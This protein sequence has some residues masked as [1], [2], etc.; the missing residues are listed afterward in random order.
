MDLPPSYNQNDQNLSANDSKAQPPDYQPSP[1]SPSLLTPL[2][3]EDDTSSSWQ[4][5]PHEPHPTL[6]LD[7]CTIYSSTH[8]SRPLYILSNAPVEALSPAY[9]LEKVYYKSR[10]L[11]D[12]SEEVKRSRTTYIY[13]IALE[14][15]AS[16][17]KSVKIKGQRSSKFTY[18]EVI[19]SG[20]GISASHYKAS[21]K[22][23]SSNKKSGS[24]SSSKTLPATENFDM[25][26]TPV[27]A[28]PRS[29]LSWKSESS[30]GVLLATETRGTRDA[31]GKMI[32]QP[33]LEIAAGERSPDE[34]EMDILVAA[35]CARV[36][37][38]AAKDTKEPMSWSKFK[39]IAGTKVGRYDVARAG[40]FL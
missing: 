6:I 2:T 21:V 23:P 1:H 32:V 34:K 18:R 26:I 12:G 14:V 28:D 19:L 22:G 27:M 16:I 29:K 24:S 37:R 20:P 35:W 25:R 17:S 40:G 39:R 38:E 10:A 15:S 33:R 11:E 30:S 31:S 4:P 13:D 7:N 36:W 8:P 3:T 5:V 9:A